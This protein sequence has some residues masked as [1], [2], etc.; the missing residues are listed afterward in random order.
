[1]QWYLCC[2]RCSSVLRITVPVMCSTCYM[3]TVVAQ[4]SV[5]SCVMFA[6]GIDVVRV[7]SS[8]TSAQMRNLYSYPQQQELCMATCSIPCALHIPTQVT[9]AVLL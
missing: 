7:S 4:L 1:V 6:V 8:I 5:G 9:T 2:S 3:H